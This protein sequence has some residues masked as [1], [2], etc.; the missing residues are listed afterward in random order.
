MILQSKMFEKYIVQLR[1]VFAMFSIPTMSFKH[2]K[3]FL[4]YIEVNLLVENLTTS[5]SQ[6]ALH[7]VK[8]YFK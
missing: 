7:F 3:T 8:E 6:F 4:R 5:H 2:L 1:K